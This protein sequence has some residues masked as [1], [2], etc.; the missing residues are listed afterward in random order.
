LVR[1]TAVTTLLVVLGVGVYSNCGPALVAVAAVSEAVKLE[2]P[3]RLVAAS[4]P[5]PVAV[6]A[7]PRFSV[8]LVSPPPGAETTS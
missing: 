4:S 7:N 8:G 5:V 2:A 1:L 6:T 3:A